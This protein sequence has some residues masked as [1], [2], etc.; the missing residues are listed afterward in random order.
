[1]P[2]VWDNRCLQHYAVADFGGLGAREM[3][4]V[5]SLGEKPF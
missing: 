1:M 5:A 3:E 2:T 4:H